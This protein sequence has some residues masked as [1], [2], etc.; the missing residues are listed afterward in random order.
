MKRSDTTEGKSDASKDK[1]PQIPAP[2]T[3]DESQWVGE[4]W[5]RHRFVLI[6]HAARKLAQLDIGRAGCDAEDVLDEAFRKICK[7]QTCQRLSAIGGDDAILKFLLTTL[8]F[9]ILDVRKRMAGA[10]CCAA[11]ANCPSH[12]DPSLRSDPSVTPGQRRSRRFHRED[13]EIEQFCA[14]GPSVDAEVISDDWLDV[15]LANRGDPRLHVIASMLRQ[16]WHTHEIALRLGLSSRT[17][18]RKIVLLRSILEDDKH[19]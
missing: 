19:E 4:L 2:L 17:I 18:E 1:K 15:M 14:T 11:L 16:G 13:I 5:A 12:D 7:R 9:V 10:E 6:A 8:N 3:P